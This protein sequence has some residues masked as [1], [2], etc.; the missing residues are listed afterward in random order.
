MSKFLA[1]SLFVASL[2]I[3]ATAANAD[4]SESVS[5]IPAKDTVSVRIVSLNGSGCPAGTAKAQMYP[6]GTGFRVF[7][8]DFVVQDG[9]GLSPVDVRK[10]CQVNL[11]VKAPKGYTYAVSKA[12]YRGYAHLV[13]G[14]VGTQLSH[15]YFTGMSQT[16]TYKHTF[17]GP[18]LGSW[19]VV[20][21]PSL[22]SLKFAPCG[23]NRNLNIN[24]ELR[25]F[26]DSEAGN[27]ISFMA[28]DTTSARFSTDYD[29]E[30][31][32]CS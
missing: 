3:P 24:T 10:N 1:T 29:F 20:D 26:N 30:W 28:M 19:S 8:D 18:Y 23:E 12:A 5:A 13:Q 32:T 9:E 21:V 7:Y 22:D 14:A 27:K 6:D 2:I 11:E 4:S 15:F 16:E 25:V 31:K 17:K